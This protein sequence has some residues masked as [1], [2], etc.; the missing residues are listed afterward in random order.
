MAG[1]K[2]DLV[3]RY[4]RASG[5]RRA[6]PDEAMRRAD[7]LE[8][9]LTRDFFFHMNPVFEP[10]LAMAYVVGRYEAVYDALA[11]L[12][13]A[14][15]LEIGCAQGLSTWLMTS[16]VDEVV[17]L[18]IGPERVVVGRHMFPE[19]EMVCEDWRTYLERT[20]RVFDV[21]VSSHGPIIW[22]EALP[23]YCKRFIN[24]GYRT[25]S[26]REGL[27]G[28]HKIAGR[29]L[30]FSTTMW[31]AAPSGGWS[32]RYLKYFAR[33]NWLKEARHALSNGYVLPV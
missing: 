33:R 24:V 32:P 19:I 3:Q 1:S 17:G 7:G 27:T 8:I 6:W 22:D 23:R 15:V 2:I 21:I 31:E 14:S 28:G 10:N 11:D 4:C 9:K 16:W 5:A 25:G 29:Q 26:W 13:P 12:K 30:S 20:G 18:D